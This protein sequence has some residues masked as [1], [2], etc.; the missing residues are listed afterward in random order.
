MS[1]Y[2]D[3]MSLYEDDAN[4]E[5]I[6]TIVHEGHTLG[7]TD[8]EP[9]NPFVPVFYTER[10]EYG[11][12]EMQLFCKIADTSFLLDSTIC[13]TSAASTS[14]ARRELH[15]KIDRWY[16]YAVRLKTVYYARLI[17][18]LEK[19]GPPVPG[20]VNH[21]DRIDLPA[22]HLKEGEHTDKQL[23]ALAHNHARSEHSRR[24]MILLDQQRESEEA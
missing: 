13:T 7:V 23:R 8:S 16:D 11:D 9:S 3:P 22:L 17:E 1:F 20:V 21:W 6:E 10:T 4:F 19:L 18:E 24:C 14:K 5:T 12:I 2:R 15:E